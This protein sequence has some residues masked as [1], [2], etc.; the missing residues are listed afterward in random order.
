MG[1]PAPATAST[2][3]HG[4]PPPFGAP[5]RQPPASMISPLIS[6]ICNLFA[7]CFWGLFALVGAAL[8]GIALGIHQSHPQASRVLAVIS[9]VVFGLEVLLGVV[10]FALY[11]YVLFTE[12]A[13]ADY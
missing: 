3:P 10:F 5:H 13:L 8:A 1:G 7:L 4:G 2:P 9:W 11:G 6:L 12:L